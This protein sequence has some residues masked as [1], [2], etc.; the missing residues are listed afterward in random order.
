MDYHDREFFVSRIR[1]GFNLVDYNYKIIKIYPPTLDDEFE[2]N[3]FYQKVYNRCLNDELLTE[4]ECHQ[5]LV[6]QGLWREKDDVEIKQVKKDIEKLKIDIFS[7]RNEK[8]EVQRLK[9][10][11][12]IIEKALEKKELEKQVY[13]GNTCEAIAQIEK[14]CFLLKKGCYLGSDLMID[15]EFD[16]KSLL[17]LYYEQI[18]KDYEIREIARTDPWK[19]QWSLKD[20]TDLYK[21]NHRELTVDQ[22]N[23]LIW[24][25]LYDSISESMEA[26]SEQVMEDDDMLDGWLILQ[27]KKSE[28]EKGRQDLES[29]LTNSK[30]AS[31]S[32]VFVFAQDEEH[33]ARIEELNDLNGKVKKKERMI[34]IKRQGEASDTD[35]QDQKIKLGNQKAE[36]FKS[37]FRG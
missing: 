1:A 19:T 16:Y 20:N 24:S 30:I 3:A 33:A 25:R 5:L 21:D 7:K 23:L 9:A 6:Q 26:P 17:N 4:K 32:E 29:S 18:L 22:K 2:S 10:Y 34:V 13:Y 14:N 35:F 27:R 36:Q 15:D 28:K 8:K 12:R 11:L 31:A 37:R